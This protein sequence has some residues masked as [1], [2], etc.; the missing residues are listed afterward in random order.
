MLPGVCY[1][2]LDLALRAEADDDV[3]SVLARL[4]AFRPDSIRTSP[5][6]RCRVLA[7]AIAGACGGVVIEDERLL[8][9]DFGAWEGMAWDDV[10][11]GALDAWA[12]DLTGFAPPGG[13]SGAALV[14]R[15]RAAY[16]AV[17]REGCHVVVSHGGPLRVLAALAA[18]VAVDL[19]VAAQA[20]GAVRVFGRVVKPRDA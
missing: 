12:A 20:P 7:A 10:P 11:R 3:A 13:E 1:G 8:E 16:A 15:C 4:A 17:P 18:G 9:L 5:S 2:R 14:A 19:G 6:L